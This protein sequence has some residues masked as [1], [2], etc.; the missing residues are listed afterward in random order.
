MYSL[1]GGRKDPIN[2]LHRY[3]T[4][5]RYTYKERQYFLKYQ[6]YGIIVREY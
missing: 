2:L 3:N 4:Y 5:S 1:N 6:I